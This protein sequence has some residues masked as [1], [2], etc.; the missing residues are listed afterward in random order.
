[1]ELKFE[2]N[3]LYV[4]GDVT[5]D[6]NADHLVIP[7]GA[8]I[9]IDLG[10]VSSMNSCGVR[11]WVEWIENNNFH[12]TYLNCT[13]SIV[14]QFNMVSEFLSSGARVASFQVPMYCGVCRK[15]EIRLLKEGIDYKAGEHYEMGSIHCEKTECGMKLNVDPDS[16]FYF[17]EMMQSNT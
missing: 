3:V 7:K 15:R 14:L 5:E 2:G 9:D 16:Y 1:M 4:I 11:E 12:P 10:G 13:H 17:L 6:F 8:I